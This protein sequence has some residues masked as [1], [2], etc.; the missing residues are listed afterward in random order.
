MKNYKDIRE[1]SLAIAT[2]LD[3]YPVT[4]Q[5][6]K[7]R[8][9]TKEEP[10]KGDNMYGPDKVTLTGSEKDIIKYADLYL[11]WDGS[12]FRELKKELGL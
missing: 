3:E 12:S 2:D 6:K 1:A 5:A 11:G 7:L 10:G 4:K 8:L 9:K